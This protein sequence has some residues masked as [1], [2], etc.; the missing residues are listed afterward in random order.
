[1]HHSTCAGLPSGSCPA[2]QAA[3]SDLGM[4]CQQLQRVDAQL[5]TEVLTLR[6]KHASVAAK[7]ITAS[8]RIC[9]FVA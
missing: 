5:V 3:L 9:S 2:L 6:A 1:M 8:P 4:T 7:V